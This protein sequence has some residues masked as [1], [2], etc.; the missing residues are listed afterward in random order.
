MMNNLGSEDKVGRLEG[1]CSYLWA[2]LSFLGR[3]GDK[4]VLHNTL[5]KVFVDGDIRQAR[6]MLFHFSESPK[7]S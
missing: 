1:L 6:S 5:L 2:F 3:V 4:Q 7:A